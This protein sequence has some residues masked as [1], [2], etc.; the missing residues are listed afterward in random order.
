MSNTKTTATMPSHRKI[1]LTAGLLYLLT[2]VS[3]P[4]L[5]MYSQVKSANYI[6]SSGSDTS[7]IIGAILEVIVALAGIGTAIVLFP[8]LKKQS[9]SMALG[10]VASRILEASSIFIGAAVI[11]TIVTLHQTNA[12]SSAL[13]SSHTLSIIYDRIFLQSQSFM[14]AINDLLLGLLLYKS[15]LV[16][17]ALSSLGIFGAFMLLAG[18]LAIMFNVAPQHGALAG[19]AGMFVA[20]FEF[21]L[22]IWLVVKGFNPKAVAA[23]ESASK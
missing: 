17:R 21:S 20:L 4:T 10:L 9:E 5:A 16:P 8:L 11:M 7:A 23:L 13:A 18:Y 1:S 14:P 2:F 22:G 3:I 19:V 12:G 15:R 6:T